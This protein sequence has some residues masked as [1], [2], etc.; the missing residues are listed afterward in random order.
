MHAWLFNMRGRLTD[1]GI[2]HVKCTKRSMN[3]PT[4]HECD[5]VGSG[6]VLYPG[7]KYINS[8]YVPLKVTHYFC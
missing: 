7:Y 6:D 1:G 2:S 5:V 3:T 4:Q 8:L